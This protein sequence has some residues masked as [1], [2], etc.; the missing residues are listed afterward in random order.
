MEL[1]KSMFGTSGIRGIYGTE[2]TEDLAQG[3][4]A[5]FSK[6]L[7][8]A[9]DIRKSG[10]KLLK[11]VAAGVGSNGGE[12]IDFG[13]V[14]TPTLALGTKIHRIRGIMLTAS[15]NPPEYNGLKLIENGKEIG[16][17][18][19]VEVTSRY[20]SWSKKS[21]SVTIS[22]DS[23]I[24][25]RHIEMIEDMVDGKAITT[26]KPKVI[27]DCNGAAC[28]I[29]P[30]L[31]EKLGCRVISVNASFECF[32][33]PS[34]PK[35]ENLPYMSNLIRSSG[36]DFA[37]AHDGDGDRCIVFDELGEALHF[38]VQ[39]EMMIEHELSATKNKKIV[40]T[41]ESSLS[42]RD[43]VERAG[44]T[45]DI[46]PVGSTHVGDRMEETGAVFGGEPCGEYIYGKGVHVPDAILAAAKF[47]EIFSTAGK[48][49]KLKSRYPQSF[50]AREK[51]SVKDK[52]ATMERIKNSLSVNGKV[53]SDDGIR[54]DQ[55]D[56]WFLI[57][58]SGTEP[59]VR[60]TVEY[61][62]QQKTSQKKEELR[63]L[64]KKCL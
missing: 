49:S 14:P 16:K 63:V 31:L 20:R 41:V 62:T 39:L 45:I 51:L 37:I 4:A 53:R 60:L 64:I 23:D 32:N 10:P 2:I 13:I 19:E 44:G 6:K 1:G 9:R 35:A 8:V 47:A 26:K 18:L 42:I 21:G 50:I 57:R 25:S 34:E 24:T 33:R 36:A 46:T 52:Y 48:F 58:A 17:D 54:V 11:A 28:A 59:I 38:D 7:V 5:V 15:H 56:G 3:V 30:Y 22:H 40:S 12:V 55:E 29:T 27:V 61:K 43:G